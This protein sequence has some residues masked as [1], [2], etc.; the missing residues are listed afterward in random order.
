MGCSAAE[1]TGL[2]FVCFAVLNPCVLSANR[3]DFG[4]FCFISFQILPPAGTTSLYLA[5]M[6]SNMPLVRLLFKSGGGDVQSNLRGKER[7]CSNLRGKE[8][9]FKS[10]GKERICSNLRGKEREYVQILEGRRENMF[11]S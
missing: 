1:A 10:R 8:R 2:G 6:D 5:V 3:V 11:K 9:M 4:L 7:I